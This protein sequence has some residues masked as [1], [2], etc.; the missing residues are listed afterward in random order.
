MMQRRKL[1][2]E[3]E[4]KVDRILSGCFNKADIDGMLEL[5]NPIEREHLYALVDKIKPAPSP[6]EKRFQKVDYYKTPPSILQFVEDDYYLGQ[7]LRPSSDNIGLYPFWRDKLVQDFD[8]PSRI[9]N[10]VISGS[11]GIGKTLLMVTILLYRLTLVSLMRNPQNFVGQSKNQNLIFNLLS[12]TREAVRQTAFGTALS[13][14][15]QSPFFIEELGFK[16]DMEYA[17]AV[18]PFRNNIFLTAGSKSWH[19]LGRNVI[20]VG[21]D[22]GNFR[23][24]AN[25][26]DSAYALYGEMR[27]R[28]VNR[29]QKAKNYLPAITIIASSAQ[30]ESSFTEQ[31]IKDIEKVASS[32]T[33]IVYREAAYRVKRHL[34]KIDKQRWFRVAYGLKNQD[35]CLLR[36]FYKE[37]GDPIPGPGDMV[38]DHEPPPKGAKTELVPEMYLADFKRN[39]RR[40]LQDVSGIAVGGSHRLFSTMIDVERCL[41]ISAAEGVVDPVN[42]RDRFLPLVQEDTQD[43]WHY[44]DHTKFLTRVHSRVQPKRHPSAKRYAHLDLA[45]TGKAGLAICHLVGHQKVEDIVRGDNPMDEYR[46]IVEYDFILTITNG[47]S[48]KGICYKKVC[49]FF[50]WLKNFCNYQFGLVTADQYQS[51]MPLQELTAAG[52][53]VD[54]LSID[55]DK[56]AYIAWRSGFEDHRIRLY[57]QEQMMTEAEYLSE[58]DRKY[59][60]PPHGSKDTTDGCAGAYLNAVNSGERVATITGT[61]PAIHTTTAVQAATEVPPID[62]PPPAAAFRKK[63]TY[64]V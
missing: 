16:P 22:E 49:D 4:A 8:V 50:I 53:E 24:E 36:G 3:T 9:N 32:E 21:M 28:I 17:K 63:R 57:R 35:P 14:M 41:E 15:G 7:T 31:V 56:S 64:A 54:K 5:L 58:G 44:L 55:R 20:G 45:T 60:H 12:V 23:L 62:L 42:G 1:S 25:P 2:K 13:F 30:D 39:C 34:L 46:L 19:L 11:L 59:D 47:D 51:V 48:G 38:A 40:G 27:T 6:E 33:Q 52:F 29:F 37:N 10:L 18:V 43:L 26:D 61:G